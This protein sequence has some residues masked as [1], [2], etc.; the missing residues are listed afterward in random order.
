MYS[1]DGKTAI[2]TGVG[3]GI[4]ARRSLRDAYTRRSLTI[5]LATHYP[6]RESEMYERLSKTQ[7][8]GRMGTPDEIAGLALYLCSD[9]AAFITGAIF[10]IDGG[11]V[12]VKP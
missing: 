6:G 9:E 10:P 1:L 11:F 7:R 5:Y 4:D 12:T 3:P 2:I 8:I